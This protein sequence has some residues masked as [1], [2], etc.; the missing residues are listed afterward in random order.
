MSPPVACPWCRADIGA[1]ELLRL[2]HFVG[3]ITA[4]HQVAP[5]TPCSV[6]RS[7]SQQLADTVDVLGRP[8]LSRSICRQHVHRLLDLAVGDGLVHAKPQQD[9]RHLGS[10]TFPGVSGCQLQRGTQFPAFGVD[11]PTVLQDDSHSFEVN[12]QGCNM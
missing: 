8:I 2:P 1:V 12:P 6:G 5:S 11:L 3:V 9:I 7:F 4:Q 10:S